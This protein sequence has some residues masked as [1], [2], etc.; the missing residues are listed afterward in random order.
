MT[1]GL[2]ESNRNYLMVMN[3]KEQIII[4]VSIKVVP[5][6]VIVVHTLYSSSTHNILS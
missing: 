4:G 3:V 5:M 6:F 2:L 1:I